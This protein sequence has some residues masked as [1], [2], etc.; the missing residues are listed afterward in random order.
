MVDQIA[1]LAFW[2]NSNVP[3]GLQQNIFSMN[4]SSQNNEVLLL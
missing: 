1:V 3:D 2:N 4:V